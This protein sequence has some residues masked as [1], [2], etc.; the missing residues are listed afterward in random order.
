[1]LKLVSRIVLR[2]LG[3][4]ESVLGGDLVSWGEIKYRPSASEGLLSQE[5]YAAKSGEPFI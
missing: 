2:F 4:D 3:N 5:K 1:M